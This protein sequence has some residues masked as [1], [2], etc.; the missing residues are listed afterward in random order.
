MNVKVDFTSDEIN[1]SKSQGLVP[2]VVQ[3]VLDNSVLMLAYMNREALQKTLD[4][5]RATFFSRSRSVLWVKGE[6]SGNYLHVEE[7]LKDCDND[8]ILLRV[9]PTGPS[10]HEGTWSCFSVVD[11]K[12]PWLGQLEKII[13]SRR[14]NA[15]R[16]TS[17]V[18]DLLHSGTHA[19]SRKIGEEALEVVLAGV[20]QDKESIAEETADLLFHM[21]V[22]LCH[23]EI[24]LANVIAILQARNNVKKTLQSKEK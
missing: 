19:I 17:Y 10:C 11:D 2:A 16:E 7:V 4:T 13:H 21:M 12:N 22:N 5:A 23:H 8:T 9:V 18:A 24:P 20:Q 1:W 6:T 15:N 14:Q 3:S